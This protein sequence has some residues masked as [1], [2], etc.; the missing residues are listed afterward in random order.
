LPPHALTHRLLRHLHVRHRHSRSR[1]GHLFDSW[2]FYDWQN[3]MCVRVCALCVPGSLV[4][5]GREGGSS[6]EEGE[7]GVPLLFF[8]GWMH[9]RATMQHDV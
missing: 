3:A 8:H 6:G 7:V 2:N 1:V 9:A 4:P 5:N